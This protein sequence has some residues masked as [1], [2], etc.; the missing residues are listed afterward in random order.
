MR[1]VVVCGVRNGAA[2]GAYAVMFDDYD[3][4]CEQ[5]QLVSG[6]LTCGVPRVH[7]ECRGREVSAALALACPHRRQAK[8]VRHG[9]ARILCAGCV[10]GLV[11]D[12]LSAD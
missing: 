3:C 7:M 2:W 12:N 9:A 11:S 6:M 4:D 5:T 1:T 8:A 10:R